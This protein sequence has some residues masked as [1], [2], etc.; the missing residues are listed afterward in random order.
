M[1]PSLRLA[2]R[3]FGNLRWFTNDVEQ[4]RDELDDQSAIRAYGLA[5]CRAPLAQFFVAFS[6]QW[7]DQTPK[8]LGQRR[9]WDVAFVLIELAR[10]KPPRGG[11]KGFVQLIDQCGLADAEISGNEH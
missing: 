3:Q 2:R 1:K 6:E 8:S 11:D 7:A 5:K 4:F 9:V 10:G